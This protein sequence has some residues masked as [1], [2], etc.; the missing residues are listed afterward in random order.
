VG[1][2]DFERAAVDMAE[3]QQVLARLRGVVTEKEH[4]LLDRLVRSYAY[5]TE[6]L[7]KKETTLAKL[8]RIIFGPRSEKTS[9]VLRGEPKAQSQAA[10]ADGPRGA[11]AG[12]KTQAKVVKGHGRNG[13]AQ[14][15]G[16]EKIAVAHPTLIT[17][18]PCP[19]PQC[20]GGKVYRLSEPAR[21]V[22]I[23]GQP[24]LMA[25]LYERERLRCHL[26]GVVFTAP[27]PAGVGEDKYDASAGSMVALLKYGSGTPWYRLGKLQ[28]H[29]GIPLPPSTQWE[30]V[31]AAAKKIKPAQTELIR[32]AAQ[33]ALFHND[34]T[35]M[36]VR[37]LMAQ[38]RAQRLA[39]PAP[40]PGPGPRPAGEADEPAERTGIF[41]T[42]I[43]ARIVEKCSGAKHWVALFF[44]GRQHAGEN[45][46]QVL[47]Q[48]DPELAAPMQMCDA[49]A[50]NVSPEFQTILGN[51]LSHARREF[52]DQVVNFP[53]EC[54]HVLEVLGQVYDHDAQAKAL[55][56]SDQERLRWHQEHS[57]PLMDELYQWMGTQI[58]Q[59]L[60]EPNSGVGQAI[61]FM[62]KHWVKL[63]L[64]LRVPGAPLDNNI[65]ER[66]LKKAIL[67]R[68]NA[69]FYRTKNGAAVGDLFMSL[70]H[71][72]ELEGV[73]PFHYLTALQ[74][75]W[76]ELARDPPAWMPWNYKAT[77]ERL[78]KA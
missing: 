18:Q 62:R 48:R 72:A 35:P 44:T 32:Q 13:A 22:W 14:Y 12:A 4:E 63:T 46:S 47:E 2:A 17:G 6:L 58:E 60:V 20:Q 52:V 5:L 23:T 70:I 75:H 59:R 56:L 67:H 65:C 55:N 45:L 38:I 68:K 15:P 71:T 36:R 40:S 28:G 24:P 10:G 43:V 7:A 73:N 42:G 33:A 57:Q 54:G 34:D 11:A 41:T 8:R 26:C 30:I 21:I 53:Q 78:A 50:R 27:A 69:L 74:R 51:C 3:V 66:A 49:L 19:D 9:K 25:T 61:R 39:L 16:A 64:F 1:H 76:Q 77:L 31:A 37:E 29:L